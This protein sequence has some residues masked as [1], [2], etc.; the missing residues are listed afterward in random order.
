MLKLEAPPTQAD[1]PVSPL[2]LTTVREG[3]PAYSLREVMRPGG[4]G[5][6]Y[7]RLQVITVPREEPG[8][9]VV[10]YEWWYDLGPW[11]KFHAEAFQIMGGDRNR[12]TGRV[13]V[14]ETV[15]S[16]REIA[17]DM[18]EE[19]PRVIWEPPDYGL[20]LNMQNQLRRDQAVG[21]KRYGY[22]ARS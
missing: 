13:W 7:R 9:G 18:R 10:M 14:V 4:P 5:Q 11:R 15:A 12:V 17:D 1:I 3:D 19:R 22:E 16:I 20:A 8:K 6:G 2:I 21:R